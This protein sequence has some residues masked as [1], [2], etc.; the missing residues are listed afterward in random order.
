MRE[1]EEDT[2]ATGRRVVTA[3][4]VADTRD[5]ERRLGLRGAG[6]AERRM[7]FR[8]DDAY[9]EMRVPSEPPRDEAGAWLYGQ[10]ILTDPQASAVEP[11]LVAVL[12]A[13][14]GY[15]GAVRATATGDFAVP[16]GAIAPGETL[17]VD[18]EPAEGPV[19][20]ATFEV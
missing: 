5:S 13:E 14:S 3:E 15:T 19:V 18:I 16:Y 4:L 9:L 11:P 7:L 10:V 12:R 17:T 20:R 6:V 8:T 1:R 2:P